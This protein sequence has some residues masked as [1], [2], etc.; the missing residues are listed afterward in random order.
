MTETVTPEPETSEVVMAAQETARRLSEEPEFAGRIATILDKRL[1][2]ALTT[3]SLG[4]IAQGLAEYAGWDVTN[5][6]LQAVVLDDFDL[7]FDEKDRAQFPAE[8]SDW[9]RLL[10]G[11]Y[12]DVLTKAQLMSRQNPSD[13]MYFSR[14]VYYE[15]QR[16]AWTVRMTLTK[17]NGAEFEIV[18]GPNTVVNL[19]RELLSLLQELPTRDVFG[20]PELEQMTGEIVAFQKK[21]FVPEQAPDATPA[22]VAAVAEATVN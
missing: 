5:L 3:D 1:G 11:E 14:E 12:T 8:L 2:P 13:W 6:I 15:Q 16:Q 7:A 4:T 19:V 17:Y 21:F 18:G 22:P 9:L 20:N 10:R